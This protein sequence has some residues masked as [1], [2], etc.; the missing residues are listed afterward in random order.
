M[1]ENSVV[2]VVVVHAGRHPDRSRFSGGGRDLARS[3]A[4]IVMV[5][6]RSLSRLKGAGFRDDAFN[7]LEIFKPPWLQVKIGA[8]D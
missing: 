5:H 4:G 8:L 6:A 7:E 3:K 2:V 1:F